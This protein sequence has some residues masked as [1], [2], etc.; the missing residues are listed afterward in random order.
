MGMEVNLEVLRESGLRA[1]NSG[2]EIDEWKQRIGFDGSIG[3]GGI[4]GFDRLPIHA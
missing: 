2:N 4:S 1:E 3:V